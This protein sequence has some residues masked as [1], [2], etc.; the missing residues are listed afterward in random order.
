[1]SIDRIITYLDTNNAKY[2]IDSDVGNIS[3]VLRG[4]Q[5]NLVEYNDFITLS[6]GH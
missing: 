1:M 3:L 5:L 2:D 6:T 4:F